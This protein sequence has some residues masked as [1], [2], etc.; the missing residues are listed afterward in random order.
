MAQSSPEQ[1][2]SVA[3]QDVPSSATTGTDKEY[4]NRILHFQSKANDKGEIPFKIVYKVS[5]KK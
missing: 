2:A 4:G 5:R 3:I 1:D